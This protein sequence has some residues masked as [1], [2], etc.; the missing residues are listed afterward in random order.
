VSPRTAQRD[1][2]KARLI[3]HDVLRGAP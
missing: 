1:W 3:L 2:N